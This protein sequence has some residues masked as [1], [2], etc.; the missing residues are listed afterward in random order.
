MH[1]HKCLVRKLTKDY[2]ELK[3]VNHLKYAFLIKKND[4]Q[5]RTEETILDLKSEVKKLKLLML[6]L[7]KNQVC[8]CFIKYK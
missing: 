5:S 3:G 1:F 6:T 7:V 4:Q 2:E 8:I